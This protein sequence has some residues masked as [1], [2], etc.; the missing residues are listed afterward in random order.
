MLLTDLSVFQIRSPFRRPILEQFEVLD[1]AAPVLDHDLVGDRVRRV[2][3]AADVSRPERVGR[4]VCES[5]EKRDRQAGRSHRSGVGRQPEA[6]QT[7]GGV[8]GKA[9]RSVH[10]SNQDGLDIRRRRRR[11]RTMI[12]C[13]D[14]IA[15]A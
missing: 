15:A 14:Q 2:V 3:P 6:E 1:D 9:A 13:I 12:G 5:R 10:E 4:R 7:E 11:I 8:E